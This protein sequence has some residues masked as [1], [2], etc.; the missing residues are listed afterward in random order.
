LRVLRRALLGAVLGLPLAASALDSPVLKPSPAMFRAH[1]ERFFAKL[2][3]NSIAIL[4]AAPLRM[5]SNDVEY[6][7]RQDSD[8]WYLTGIEDPEAIAVLRPNAADGKRYVVFVKPR[9]LRHDAQVYRLFTAEA[10]RI[11][12]KLGNEPF[13]AKAPAKI[14]AT[15]EERLAAV[16]ARLEGLRA[17]VSELG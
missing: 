9:E 12:A 13:R 17:G 7:Y 4:R 5:M 8:F 11:E 14:I 6:L 1:R 3:P 10:G 16:R 15:E 2:P